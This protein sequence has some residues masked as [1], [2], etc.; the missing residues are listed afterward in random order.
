M[1]GLQDVLND[2]EPVLVAHG[3]ENCLGCPALEQEWNVIATVFL[4]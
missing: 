4:H 3:I 1:L 2:G